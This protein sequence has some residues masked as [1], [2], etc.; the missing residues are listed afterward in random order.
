MNRLGMLIQAWEQS[1]HLAKKQARYE[2]CWHA[3]P[4]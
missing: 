4:A 2:A 1:P 3:V